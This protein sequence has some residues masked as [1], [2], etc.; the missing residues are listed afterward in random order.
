MNYTLPSDVDIEINVREREE[1]LKRNGV[2]LPSDFIR[3]AKECAKRAKRYYRPLS[4]QDI[5]NAIEVANFWEKATKNR[6]AYWTLI[7]NVIYALYRNQCV[8]LSNNPECRELYLEK[9]CEVDMSC[10]LANAKMDK[11]HF[12][13][14]CV[15]SDHVTKR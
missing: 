14:I 12:T 7:V 1:S 5:L 10:K 9:F 8:S 4:E 6:E 2:E 11:I 3:V 15:G 13:Q